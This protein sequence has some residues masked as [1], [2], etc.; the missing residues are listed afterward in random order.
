MRATEQ[1]HVGNIHDA[2]DDHDDNNISIQYD[3][4]AICIKT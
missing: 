3:N 1:G 4:I 2:D